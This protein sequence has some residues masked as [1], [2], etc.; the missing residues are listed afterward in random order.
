MAG[1]SIFKEVIPCGGQKMNRL[2]TKN[3]RVE[4]GLRPLCEI[5]GCKDIVCGK[6]IIIQDYGSQGKWLANVCQ[7]HYDNA[8]PGR[9]IY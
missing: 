8:H 5:A 7:Q 9:K 6:Q 2:K 3:R 4:L 1:K